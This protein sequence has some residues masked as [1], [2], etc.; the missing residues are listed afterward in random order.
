FPRSQIRQI[1]LRGINEIQL[2]ARGTPR[3]HHI[4]ERG[5]VFPEQSEES[6]APLANFVEPRRVEIHTAGILPDAPRELLQRVE[7]R[8][9][10]LLHPRGRS[11][12]ALNG[13]ERALCSTEL[14][15]DA[16][17]FSGQELVKATRKRAELVGV[18]ED[19]CFVLEFC[20]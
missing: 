4:I 3:L 19:A 8:I 6:V 16:C 5:A 18:L 14:T 7:S 20:I 12:N 1:E 10:Q 2:R 9:E 17:I 11:I 15:Q 13:C